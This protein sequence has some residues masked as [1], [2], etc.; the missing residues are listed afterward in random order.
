MKRFLFLML[1][2]FIVSAQVSKNPNTLNSYFYVQNVDT[3]TNVVTNPSGNITT[4]QTLNAG[5]NDYGFESPQSLTFYVYAGENITG[6]KMISSSYIHSHLTVD[7]VAFS[8]SISD[9]SISVD[10]LLDISVSDYSTGELEGICY[11]YII[12]VK[13]INGTKIY[14]ENFLV[15]GLNVYCEEDCPT[16]RFNVSWSIGNIASYDT[17]LVIKSLNALF[18]YKWFTKSTTSFTDSSNAGWTE[19][20]EVWTVDLSLTTS[21]PVKH[22][23]NLSW[24]AVSGA[25]F[26][27]LVKTNTTS[28]IYD[29]KDM[30]ARTIVDSVS[31]QY[32]TTLTSTT[33]ADYLSTW[34]N[35]E[36]VYDTTTSYKLPA[37]TVTTITQQAN[38]AWGG[39]VYA[40][41]KE[42]NGSSWT[43]VWKDTVA[44]ID[45]GYTENIL[46]DSPTDLFDGKM[47]YY[48]RIR[49]EYT[50]AVSGLI[51]KQRLNWIP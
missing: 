24:S 31:T 7:S 35:N 28:D 29:V 41:V 33:Y 36:S 44:F 15:G 10:S 47:N 3:V 51:R 21:Y 37:K 45:S 32:D 14:P 8:P 43:N 34:E 4:S 48:L 6:G 20:S 19:T 16:V 39:Y 23:Y 25:D 27:R 13:I 46:K 11:Y 40:D 2:P 12:P 22:R 1:I 38:K 18:Y 50:D 17:L 9:S 5:T 49:T 30:T 26:Y 42:L